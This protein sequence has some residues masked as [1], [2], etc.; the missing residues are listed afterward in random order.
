MKI[1][2]GDLDLVE[3][4]FTDAC[5]N[6]ATCSFTVTVNP[7]NVV[8]V[9]LELQGGLMPVTR[10][11]TFKFYKCPNA[12]PLDEV[13]QEIE[14]HLDYWHNG[15]AEVQFKVECGEYDYI[16][17]EDE[18]HTLTSRVPLVVEDGHY[19][20]DFTGQD[21]R[22]IQG[23]LIDQYD[24]A[25]GWVDILDFAVYVNQWGWPWETGAGAD[26]DCETPFPHADMN[27]DGAVDESDFSFI[28]A[29]FWKIGDAAP[30]DVLRTIGAGNL[31]GPRAAITV[32]ELHLLG[33]SDLAPA[34]LNGDRVVD[35]ADIMAFMSG[36]TPK[37][38]KQ[39]PAASEKLES[40]PAE[41]APGL[42]DL[43]P[44][45]LQR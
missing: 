7:V 45:K 23:D 33:L 27:G 43:I 26:T 21:N 17:A 18:L 34:D 37:P 13:T 2:G 1:R 6:T 5:G 15:A 3:Y 11:I 16:T 40:E 25:G 32:A 12:T 38:Q 14:F 24:G 22:L 42:L 20:A 28:T 30:C 9:A 29:N 36:A 19:S 44:A 35:E 39:L 8:D 31:R 41:V 10:C 4:E